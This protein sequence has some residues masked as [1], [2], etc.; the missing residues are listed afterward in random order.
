[1]KYIFLLLLVGCATSEQRQERAI[2]IAEHEPD[3]IEK[4]T[5]YDDF[6]KRNGIML[7]KNT[8]KTYRWC[9]ECT[10]HRLDWDFY[11]RV[12]DFSRP[13]ADWRPKGGNNVR[14]VGGL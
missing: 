3:R 4:W 7:W 1:M 14:C 12:E 2:Q 6:C 10:P 11:Y 13:G 5:Y 8:V 9:R